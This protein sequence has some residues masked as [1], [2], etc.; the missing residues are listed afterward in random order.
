M[1][2]LQQN[3][4]GAYVAHRL[5]VAGFS[6]RSPL[7]YGALRALHRSSRG[8]PR[9][10]NILMHKAMLLAY[11]EGRWTI[12]RRDVRAAAADT[13]AA[14]ACGKGWWRLGLGRAAD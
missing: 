5:A 11:G 8:L 6:G 4:V 3:E 14:A 13:P 2:A 10:V 12:E 1:R 7:S 9:L